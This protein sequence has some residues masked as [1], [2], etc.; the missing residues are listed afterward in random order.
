MGIS[1]TAVA[2]DAASIILLDDNFKSI[3]VAVMW[4]RN[5]YDAIK[6]FL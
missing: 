6:K 4:G 2:R 3:V 5:V 1:G